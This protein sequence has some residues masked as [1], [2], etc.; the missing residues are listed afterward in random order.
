V[1]ET[2]DGTQIEGCDAI[3]TPPGWRRRNTPMRAFP[4]GRD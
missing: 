1:A 3:E 4:I 2:V